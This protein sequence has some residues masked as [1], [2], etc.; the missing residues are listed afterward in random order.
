MFCSLQN[1][2]EFTIYFDLKR[3]HLGRTE[4]VNHTRTHIPAL[5]LSNSVVLGTLPVSPF[6][7]LQIGRNTSA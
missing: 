7:H 5:Q 3:D 2:F 4:V 1:A 6:S